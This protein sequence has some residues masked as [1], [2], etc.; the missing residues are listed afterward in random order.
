MKNEFDA[1]LNNHN[2]DLLQMILLRM[3]FRVSGFSGLR[4]NPVVQ[5]TIVRIILDVALRFHWPLPQLKVNNAFLQFDLEEEVYMTQPPG[6]ACGNNPNHICKLRKA[7]YG[8]KQAPRA[9]YNALK[10]HLSYVGFV[11][12]ESDNSLFTRHSNTGFIFILVYVDDIIVTG[13]NCIT[14]NEFMQ[15]PSDLH[16]KS[17]K[18]VLRYLRGTIQFY[19]HVYPNIDFN[20]HMYSDAEWSGDLTDRSSVSGY[21]LFL[22]QNPISWS[23]KKHKTVA[24]SSTEA[25]Y[26]VLANALAELLWVRNILLDMRLPIRDTPTI[27]CDNIGVTYLSGNLGLHSRMKHADVDFHLCATMLNARRFELFM[28]IQLTN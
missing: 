6:Y 20:L 12:T 11:K 28:F 22:D 17:V 27:Y 9:W 13:S 19:L 15:S 23:S 1:L 2:W 14:V 10:G 8:L 16:W 3:L 5:P 24:R 26:S 25:G 7:N 18:R 21:I 4:E